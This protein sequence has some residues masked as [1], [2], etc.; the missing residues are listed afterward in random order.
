MPALHSMGT[1]I[2][3]ERKRKDSAHGLLWTLRLEDR[4]SFK[5]FSA[6]VGNLLDS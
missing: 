2:L 6:K 4:E 5:T 3:K 1:D